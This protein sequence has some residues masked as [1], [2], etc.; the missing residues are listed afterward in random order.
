[1]IFEGSKTNLIS[2]GTDQECH[3]D[4]SNVCHTAQSRKRSTVLKSNTESTF[5]TDPKRPYSS[6]VTETGY[7]LLKTLQDPLI[8]VVHSK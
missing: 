4:E 6:C 5:H 3:A 1:M 7:R 8:F 2:A